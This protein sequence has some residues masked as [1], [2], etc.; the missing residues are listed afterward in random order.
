MISPG[1]SID[2]YQATLERLAPLVERAATIVPGHGGPI[3]RPRA[4]SL[5][6]EDAAYL[7]ALLADGADAPLPPGRRSAAQRKIHEENAQRTTA[8]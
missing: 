8:Q 7:E 3:S 6:D 2:H 5:L 4:L 1:G